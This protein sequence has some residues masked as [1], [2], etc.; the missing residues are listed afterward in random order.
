MR[1]ADAAVPGLAVSLHT[2]PATFCGPERPWTERVKVD[3]L[4]TD[5][6]LDPTADA[7][8]DRAASATTEPEG[9]PANVMVSSTSAPTTGVHPTVAFAVE[10]RL[11]EERTRW[12]MQIHDGLTQAVTS[13]VL[14]IQTLRH[15]IETDPAGAIANLQE[16]ED[17]IR[18]DLH[19]IRQLMFE[20]TTEGPRAAPV[21]AGFVQDLSDRWHLPTAIDVVGDLDV[22]PAGVLDTAHAIVA[23]SLANAAKHSGTTDVVVRVRAGEGELAVEIEDHGR[24]LTAVGDDDPHFGLRIMRTR[25]ESVGGSLVVESTPGHGTTVRAVLPVGGRGGEG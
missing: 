23:E 15:R 13:A 6:E 10:R 3:R 17:E 14:E 5:K 25:A 2:T 21:F 8:R 22:L 19:R 1:R 11:L 24:G 16:I 4:P 18:E 7:R 12:A 20:M 9:R